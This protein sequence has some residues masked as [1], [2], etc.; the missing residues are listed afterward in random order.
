MLFLS[1]KYIAIFIALLLAFTP[2]QAALTKMGSVD[3]QLH[4]LSHIPEVDHHEIEVPE[5]DHVTVHV[6]DEH[7]DCATDK[8]VTTHLGL[9]YSFDLLTNNSDS[10]VF[11]ILHTSTLKGHPS[12]LIRPP[13]I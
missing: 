12:R 7:S 1:Q 2:L 6:D 8:C 3:H 10:L 4:E 9:F 13:K 11:L 5:H